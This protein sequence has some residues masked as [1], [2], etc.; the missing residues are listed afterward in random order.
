M[1][2]N[3]AFHL[4]TSAIKQAVNMDTWRKDNPMPSSLKTPPP[5]P[6]EGNLWG[7]DT[8]RMEEAHHLERIQKFLEDGVISPTQARYYMQHPA[9]IV[10]VDNQIRNFGLEST[11]GWNNAYPEMTPETN[12][13]KPKLADDFYD[14]TKNPIKGNPYMPGLEATPPPPPPPPPPPAPALPDFETDPFGPPM[15]TPPAVNTVPTTATADSGTPPGGKIPWD[16]LGKPQPTAPPVVASSAPAAPPQAPAPAAPPTPPPAPPAPKPEPAPPAPAAAPPTP[17]APAP[18]PAPPT[19]APAPAPSMDAVNPTAVAKAAPAAPP[20]A[21]RT[22]MTNR[23]RETLLPESQRGIFISPEMQAQMTAAN[24]P[25]SSKV[26]WK[27]ASMQP[28]INMLV[29]SAIKESVASTLLNG[30]SG[31]QWQPATAPKTF[32]TPAPGEIPKV[33]QKGKAAKPA[34]PATPNYSGTAPAPT[35][36]GSAKT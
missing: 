33:P 3:P 22:V 11:K 25:S 21:P 7:M 12:P 4:V 15:V 1:A 35:F 19:P 26:K 5:A 23:G 9:E 34:T 32:K 14:T 16:D 18:K 30:M 29:G 27:R 2:Y 24:T 36:P 31:K 6:S 20:P 13:T 10:N 17:P 8:K 28:H